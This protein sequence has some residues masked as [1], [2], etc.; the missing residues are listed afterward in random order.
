MGIPLPYREG[1]LKGLG[2]SREEGLSIPILYKARRGK[3]W[4]EITHSGKHEKEGGYETD[5][6]GAR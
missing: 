1:E 3:S 4:L 2:R 6:P 5:A